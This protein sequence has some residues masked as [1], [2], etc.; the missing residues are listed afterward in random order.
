MIIGWDSWQKMKIII[1]MMMK[2]ETIIIRWPG[3]QQM[4]IRWPG[5]QQAGAQGVQGA[6]DANM[7]QA[8]A[9]GAS[10]TSPRWEG[11]GPGASAPVVDH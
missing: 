4:I 3:L 10:S 6:Q 7:Q 11:G 1:Q 8:T 5:L 2:K 9:Q